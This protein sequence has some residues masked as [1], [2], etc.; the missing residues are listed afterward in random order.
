MVNLNILSR[1]LYYFDILVKAALLNDTGGSVTKARG[2]SVKFNCT[3]DGIPRPDIV[4]RKNGQLFVN[5]SRAK[6]ISS[7]ESDGFRSK[8]FP[9][10]LQRTSILEITDIDCSDNGNYS[11]RA[12]NEAFVGVVLMTKF[13]LQ[14]VECK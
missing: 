12:N 5:T 4:W 14:V 6:I 13:T 7:E 9:G 11:C 1:T 10:I 3:A 2:Q 8:F